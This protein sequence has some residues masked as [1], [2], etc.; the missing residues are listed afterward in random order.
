MSGAAGPE[1][2]PLSDVEKLRR[3]HDPSAFDCGEPSLNDWLRRYAWQN[4]AADVARTYV[5]HRA[6]RVVGY[7]SLAYGSVQWEEAPERIAK[8]LAR[9]PVPVILIARLAVDRREAGRGLG[10]AMLKDAL[11]RIKAAADIAGARAVLVHAINERARAFYEHFEFERSPVD[12]LT[13]MLLMKDLRAL[14][15]T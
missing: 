9:Y 4:Q 3:A 11:L 13:L 2:P 5:V 6:N 15:R 7:F 10:K 8:G 12:D 1:E 14:L